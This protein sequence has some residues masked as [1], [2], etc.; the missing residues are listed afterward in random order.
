[1]SS[2]AGAPAAGSGLAGFDD[3]DLAALRRR[4]SAKWTTYP[5]D[6]LP[7][8]VA[9]MDFPLAAPVRDAL[10]AAVAR[11]D[12][13]YPSAGALGTAFARFAAARY[14]WD[15]DPGRVRA[16]TD[17]MTAVSEL[18]R[19]LTEPGDAVVITPPVYPPFFTVA[20]EAGRRVVESPLAR[21]DRGYE[22]DLDGLEHAFAAGA[23]TFLLC[24]PHNP[25][26]RSFRRDE[27]EAIAEL[28]GRYG[29]VVIA[30]EIHAPMT[31]PGS[32]HVPY[33]TLGPE[34]AAGAVA[35]TGASKAWNVAGLKCALIVTG[36]AGLEARLDAAL[37]SH[38]PY[39][40]G[41]FGVLAALAAFEQGADWLDLLI[42][43]LDVNRQLLARLLAAR[44]PQIAYDPPEAGYLAWLDC[45]G[46][47]L[48]DD[49][50]SVFL[51]RGRVALSPGPN[52]G[53]QGRGFARLN[54]G[55]SAAL[56]GEAVDRLAAAVT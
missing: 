17:V 32:V 36:D 9:E 37:P 22:L 2:A 18:I 35:I 24:H 48:G 23:R 4:R 34:A 41:H 16:A 12:T 55:T 40:V 49:P 28:A 44:L 50:A 54:F 27:L 51:E 42:A 56:L 3:V 15:V 13:G 31:L 39:H 52:F 25:S 30:D 53:T 6:V 11:D 43:H 8:F 21:S 1:M 20:V 45:R 33:L 47:G 5:P 29:V 10:A 46:L 26:G 14:D 19:A 7:A 38:L